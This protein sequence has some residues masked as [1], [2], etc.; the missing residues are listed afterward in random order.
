MIQKSIESQIRALF[1]TATHFCE[2][3]VLDS[4]TVLAGDTGV[5]DRDVR[6]GCGHGLCAHIFVYG[7]MIVRI[8][9]SPFVY[10]AVNIR[11]YLSQAILAYMIGTFG[12]DVGTAFEHLRRRLNV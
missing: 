12:V 4:K 5:Y 2:V 8:S 9:L 6:G 10:G 1:G 7:A 3:L 11:I